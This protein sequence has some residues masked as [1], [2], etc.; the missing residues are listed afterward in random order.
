[1][2]WYASKL[3]IDQQFYL[4]WKLF[5]HILV[6]LAFVYGVILNCKKKIYIYIVLPY[7]K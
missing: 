3:N 6:D 4:E 1:M 7:I 2:I 5:F